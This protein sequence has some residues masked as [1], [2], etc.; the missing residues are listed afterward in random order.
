VFAQYLPLLGMTLFVLI[1]VVWRGCLQYRRYGN[2]GIV[3]FTSSDWWRL[4]R[5]TLFFLLFVGVFV[6]SVVFALSPACLSG[7]FL[8]TM[9]AWAMWT[10]RAMMAA[11]IAWTVAAQL[12]MGASWR[13]GIEHDNCPGL[14]TSGMYQF[15]RNPIYLG[16]IVCLLGITVMLTTWSSLLLTVSAIWCIRSQTLEEEAY[17]QWMYGDAFHRYAARVGRFW[18]GCGKLLRPSAAAARSTNFAAA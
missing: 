11:G 14:V 16:M 15:C 3:L 4:I 12:G 9:P 5:D 13:I 1:C 10:G 7:L 6:Q 8:V 2:F 18:P 17:L